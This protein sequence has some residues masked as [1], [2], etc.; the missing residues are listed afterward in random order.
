MGFVIAIDGPSG[1]GKSTTARAVAR[2]LGIPFLDTGALYRALALRV[3]AGGVHAEDEAAVADSAR[4]ALIDLAGAADDP[5][6]MLDGE[7]VTQAI[8]TPEVSELSSRLATQ[9]AVRRRLVE[10]QH[11][12]ARRGPVVAEGRDLGTVVFPNAQVKI[13]LDADLG[14]RAERRARELQSRGIAV[15]RDDVRL[16]LERRDLRDSRRADSPLKRADGALVVDTTRMG[17]DQQ[18]EAVLCIVAAHPDCPDGWRER[19]ARPNP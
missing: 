1:A 14:A 5:R 2:R 19:V 8:R 7:D 10:L 17:L 13:Y 4:G 16:D 6:V 15:S 12:F 9:S 11:E 3:R 18:V